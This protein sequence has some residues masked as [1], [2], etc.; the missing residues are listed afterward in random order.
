MITHGIAFSVAMRPS[1]LSTLGA[2]HRQERA[3]VARSAVVLALV[4][5]N[6]DINDSAALVAK[7]TKLGIDAQVGFRAARSSI[8]ARVARQLIGRSASSLSTCKNLRRR[9]GNVPFLMPTGS[10]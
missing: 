5:A 3:L 9:L 6:G 10:L 8:A 7:S 4:N 2:R 1:R